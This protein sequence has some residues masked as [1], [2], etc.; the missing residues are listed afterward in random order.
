MNLS[1][2]VVRVETIAGH[3][4]RA[5]PCD[6]LHEHWR[7]FS[8]G[9]FAG[10]VACVHHEWVAFGPLDSGHA[11]MMGRPRCCPSCDTAIGWLVAP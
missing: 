9:H 2:Q 8:D 7:V 10:V 11:G 3:Q 6:G 4:V 5:E 1:G